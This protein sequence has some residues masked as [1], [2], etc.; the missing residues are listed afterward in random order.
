MEMYCMKAHSPTYC[1]F[2][3]YKKLLKT[4]TTK[5]ITMY[6]SFISIKKNKQ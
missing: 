1:A 4:T 3:R 2:R 6:F 5:L